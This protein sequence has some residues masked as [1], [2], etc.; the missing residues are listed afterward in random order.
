M[1]D[2]RA[3]ILWVLRI[4]EEYTDEN[5]ILTMSRIIELIYD[6]YG[7]TL[8]RRTITGSIRSLMDYGYDI[9]TYSENKKG[10]YLR[11]RDYE[12]AEIMLMMDS[13]YSYKGI[14]A[15][16]TRDLIAKIQ[17]RLS[18]YQRK[19]YKNLIS[20]KPYKKTENKQVFYNIEVLDEAIKK[21]KQA[22]FIYNSYDFDKSLKPR[23]MKPFIVEPYLMIS[24]NEHYYLICKNLS[25]SDNISY[26]RVDRMT[27]VNILETDAKLAPEGVNFDTF[28]QK[29][30]AIYFGKEEDFKFRCKNSIL[31]DVID[32]FGTDIQIFNITDETFDFTVRLVDKA[33]LFFALEYISRCEVLMPIHARERMKRYTQSGIDRYMK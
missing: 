17:N 6:E 7:E 10:Y 8:D 33:A 20:V 26:F 32:R 15:K 22:S 14:P 30:A 29:A 2:N 24:E 16:Q 9:S 27:E 5:H 21:Q 11:E 12:V 4:L 31:D 1:K 18:I 28:S 13:I 23:R 19:N 25:Y 3:T